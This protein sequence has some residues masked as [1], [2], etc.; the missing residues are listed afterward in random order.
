MT[1]APRVSDAASVD[2]DEMVDG[3]RA[4]LRREVVPRHERGSLDL[5]DPWQTF[6]AAGRFRPE[7]VGL[8]REVREA[9]AEAGYY[10]MT[11][12]ESLGGGGLGLEALYRAWE[13][14]YHECGAHHWLGYASVAHWARGPSHVLAGASPALREQVLPDLLAGRASL[15][16]C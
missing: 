15:C 5:N 4:F 14:I 2:L 8:L 6:G 16:F 9:S 7:G 1:A 11:V 10:T 13:A 12:P 3:L